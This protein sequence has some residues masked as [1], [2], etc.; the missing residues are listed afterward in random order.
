MGRGLGRDIKCSLNKAR[1]AAMLAV[2]TYNKPATKF[3]SGGYVVLMCI[4]WT[5]LLHAIFYSHNIKPIYKKGKRYKRVDGELRFWDLQECVKQCNELPPPVKANIE[6]FIGLRN[7]I[8]HKF[9][10]EIDSNIFAECQAMLMN[11]DSLV[12]REFG[13]QYC[14]K[15][16]LSFSLQ[17]FPSPQALN[18][19]ASMGK[20]AD[21]VT[22][23]IAQ[24]RTT[25]NPEIQKS[26]EYSFKAYLIQVANHKTENALPIQFVNYNN[27]TKEE[28]A[29]L[30]AFVAMTKEKHVFVA[31]KGTL[32]PGT[33]VK[34][35]QK[36]LG[37]P[38]VFR[39]KK[40][41]DKFNMDT[42]TRCCKKYKV[43]PSDKKKEPEKTRSEFCIYDEPNNGY[44]YTEAWVDFLIKQ[45]QIQ[46]EYKSLYQNNFN[47]TADS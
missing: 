17:L 4:A 1:D 12:H 26:M 34:K 15:E 25:L 28:K 24:Y 37:N 13:E 8:E 23:F 14:L 7:K 30:S 38:K 31:N 42:H 9:M 20:D 41:I 3:K 27:L 44:L 21:Q 11:F 46:E 45:M 33:V 36:A 6:F 22:K 29:S 5:A 19:A 32:K 18:M 43:W 40:E 39:G 2:E 35:V 16:S 10:P 47:N